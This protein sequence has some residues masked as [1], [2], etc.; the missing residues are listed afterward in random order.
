[1]LAQITNVQTAGIVYRLL[2][3]DVPNIPVRAVDVSLDHSVKTV[4]YSQWRKTAL[5]FLKAIL[6]DVMGEENFYFSPFFIIQL[7]N[8][9]CCHRIISSQCIRAGYF[10]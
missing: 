4:S 1:M 8:D 5:F 7:C 3:V 10:A 9:P 2:M 6:R